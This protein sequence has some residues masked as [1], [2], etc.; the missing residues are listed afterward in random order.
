MTTTARI[1]KNCDGTQI[2]TPF[3]T[4]ENKSGSCFVCNFFMFFINK[5]VK[6]GSNVMETI[7]ETVNPMETATAWSKNNAPAIPFIK[8]SGIKTAQVVNTELINGLIISFV[9]VFEDLERSSRVVSEVGIVRRLLDEVYLLYLSICLISFA[10]LC[11]IVDYDDGIIN[12]HS[13]T[14]N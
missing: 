13:H 12:H 5:P 3:R 6:V 11:N 14:K 4:N 7:N 8:I 2:L 10:V 1:V 9:P